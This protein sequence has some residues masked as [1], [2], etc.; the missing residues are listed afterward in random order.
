MHPECQVSC[1]QVDPE[2]AKVVFES[3]ASVVMVPIEVT[4]TA[5][6]TSEIIQRL[7]AKD[8]PS[9]FLKLI[10]EIIVYFRDTYSSVF[11]FK[12]PPIHDPC[13]VFYVA[14]PEAFKVILSVSIM[15]FPPALL[16]MAWLLSS[17]ALYFAHSSV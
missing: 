16:L 12:D 6:A 2:A 9:P 15:L 5:L 13:A 3:A 14:Q 10:Q 11:G 8:P 17:I 1:L 7:L 4:H